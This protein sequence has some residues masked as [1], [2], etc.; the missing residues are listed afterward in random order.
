M[1]TTVCTEEPGYNSSF[2][3]DQHA[4][5]LARLRTLEHAFDPLSQA[6]FDQ[7]D[8]AQKPAILDLGAGAGSLAA[9]LIKR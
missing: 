4:G 7:L 5:Q 6:A 8:L 1:T 9:W 2:L 3:A